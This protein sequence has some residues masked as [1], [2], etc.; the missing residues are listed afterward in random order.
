MFA[1]GEGSILLAFLACLRCSAATFLDAS[2]AA[3]PLRR[4]V[5]QA[6]RS[7]TATSRVSGFM[8]KAFNEVLNVSLAAMGTFTPLHLTIK[9]YFWQPMI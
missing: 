7:G 8:P 6:V 1:S 2:H 3:A 4:D 9:E 5:L